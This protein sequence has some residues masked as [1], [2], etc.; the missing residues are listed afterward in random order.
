MTA[1]TQTVSVSTFQVKTGEDALRLLVSFMTSAATFLFF[2]DLIGFESAWEKLFSAG[3]SVVIFFAMDYFVKEYFRTKN[4]MWFIPIALCMATSGLGTVGTFQISIEGQLRKSDHYRRL[5]ARWA[6]LNTQVETYGNQAKNYGEANPINQRRVLAEQKKAIDDQA[7]VEQMMASL[8]ATG[9][10]KGIA[11]LA[12]RWSMNSDSFL[13]Y[14][15]ITLALGLDLFYIK[16][17]TDQLRTAFVGV[18][19]NVPNRSQKR[20]KTVTGNGKNDET[21]TTG[22]VKKNAKKL[23]VPDLDPRSPIYQKIAELLREQWVPGNMSLQNIA[24]KVRRS[25]TT[26][27]KIKEMEKIKR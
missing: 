24:D 12:E 20:P 27:H 10:V 2:K 9:S 6:T 17:R 21:G 4:K 11:K 25:K 14:V 1:T 7:K 23:D 18:P 26:V 5:E 19:G 8:P 13:F 16:L 3:W 22:N 15:L